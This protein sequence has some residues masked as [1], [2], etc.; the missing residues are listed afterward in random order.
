MVSFSRATIIFLILS[1]FLLQ[2]YGIPNPKLK[3][4]VKVDING[5]EVIHETHPKAAKARM[6]M[7][8]KAE[9]TF[10]SNTVQKMSP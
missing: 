2:C 9:G 10:P 8:S 7:D 6:M 3:V 1:S 5:K 4:D